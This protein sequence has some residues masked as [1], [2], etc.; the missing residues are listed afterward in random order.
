MEK[1]RK[2]LKITSIVLLIMAGSTMLNILGEIFFG[3]FNSAAVPEGAPA[4][5]LLVAKIILLAISALFLW[6]QVYVGIKGIKIAKNP[7]GTKGHIFWATV[8]L[9]ISILGLISP[10][11]E[12]LRS[13]GVYQNVGEILSLLIEVCLYFEYVKFAKEIAKAN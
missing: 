3:E 12:L 1:T 4:N 2:N 8:L 5:T 13:E 7:V 11:L 9:V 10:A 6:P